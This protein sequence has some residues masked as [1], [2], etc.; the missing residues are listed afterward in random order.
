MLNALE[1]TLPLVKVANSI[2]DEPVII[3]RLQLM[4]MA[5]DQITRQ[6]IM[7]KIQQQKTTF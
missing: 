7:T 1:T 6:L 2:I 3:L 5:P 4:Q